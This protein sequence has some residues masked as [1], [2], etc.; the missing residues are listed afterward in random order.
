LA[1]SFIVPERGTSSLSLST[2]LPVIYTIAP[3]SAS[4]FAIPFPTPL[5]PPVT[6]AILF[7]SLFIFNPPLF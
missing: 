4:P 6:T 2:V 3:C 1:V 7:S 5:L